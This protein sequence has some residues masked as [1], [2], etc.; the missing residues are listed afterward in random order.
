MSATTSHHKH[1]TTTGV[2]QVF[3]VHDHDEEGAI[4]VGDGEL[5][6]ALHPTRRGA[7]GRLQ[8]SGRSRVQTFCLVISD[9]GMEEGVDQVTLEAAARTSADH[10]VFAC[11]YVCV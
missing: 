9:D 11:V 2:Y 7:D 3:D 8:R 1:L 4:P 6:L 10:V 5:D